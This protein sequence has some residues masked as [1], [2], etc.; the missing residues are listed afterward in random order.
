[1]AADI[2]LPVDGMDDAALCSAWPADALFNI[3]LEGRI[4]ADVAIFVAG[5]C[6]FPLVVLR[7]H[8]QH[9]RIGSLFVS[10]V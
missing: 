2:Q 10:V 8:G 4:G 9:I 3:M 7:R 1:M 6:P 5:A